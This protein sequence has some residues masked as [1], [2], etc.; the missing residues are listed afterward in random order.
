LSAGFFHRTRCGR[1]SGKLAG[2]KRIY[3]T[4]LALL[5]SLVGAAAPDQTQYASGWPERPDSPPLIVEGSITPELVNRQP[6]LIDAAVAKIAESSAPGA[7]VYFLGFAGFGDERVFA[8]EIDMAANRVAER[9]G[10]AQRSMRLVND[11]RDVEKYP[12]ATVA[13]LRYTLDALGRVMDQDDILFLALSSH[14]SDDASIS[15]S[16]P[17]MLRD[18]LR[19]RQLAAALEHSG[20]RWRV[21]VISA[22][23]SGSFIDSLA[24]N[25]TIVLTA[26]SK[27]RASFGCSDERHLT[28]F[29]EAFYRD[30]MPTTTSLRG[31]FE[32]TRRNIREREDAENVR[33]SNPQSYFGPM[34]ESKLLEIETTV[35]RS[36]P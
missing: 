17:G 9:Y 36:R 25:R 14:G 22:C 20:I 2:V 32:V 6:G 24:D 21:I 28:Y 7:Q 8:E 15:I 19:A 10:S 13:S 5:A 26:A 11:R 29:G 3:C 30:A 16:N 35:V 1:G 27:S 33:P 23:Y 18:D 34:I 31:A 12:L 4:A